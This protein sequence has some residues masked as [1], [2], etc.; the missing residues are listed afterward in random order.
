[1]LDGKPL[2][3]PMNPPPALPV[4]P[5]APADPPDRLLAAIL[6]VLTLAVVALGGWLR[7]SDLPSTQIF[8][9]DEGFYLLEARR[10]ESQVEAVRRIVAKARE[11]KLRG[12]FRLTPA[13][14]QELETLA[15]RGLGQVGGR[16]G[17]DVYLAIARAWL[18]EHDWVGAVVG[19][20]FGTATL[21]LVALWGWWLWGAAA[22]LFAAALLAVSAMHLNYSRSTLSET[23]LAFFVALTLFIYS[24]SFDS[25]RPR[26]WAALAGVAF[27]AAFVTNLRAQPIAYAIVLCELVLR[28]RQA[29][30]S[31]VAFG[32]GAAVPLVL[33]ELFF[34]GLFLASGVS[35]AILTRQT[36]AMDIVWLALRLQ[37]GVMSPG[38]AGWSTYPTY[39]AG[40]ETPTFALVGLAGA[41]IAA[42]A[43]IRTRVPRE[44]PLL[45]SLVLMGLYWQFAVGLK[46]ARYLSTALPLVAVLGAV[47][48][49]HL[50]AWIAPATG[51]AGRRG[52]VI[53]SLTALVIGTSLPV[54]LARLPAGPS[55]R[56]V[57]DFLVAKGATK[58][59]ATQPNIFRVWFEDE[60]VAQVDSLE[61]IR[62]AHA[63]GYR[64]YVSCGQ[65]YLNTSRAAMI[66]AEREL[67]KTPPLATFPHP[68]GGSNHIW[69]ENV[70]P[71]PPA[72][73]VEDMARI[74]VWDLDAVF[75][76]R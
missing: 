16:F 20:L 57:K 4:G 75:A 6:A 43:W 52:L 74:R 53:A 73:L 22:G 9:C 61:D 70:T 58:F 5:S 65:K 30:V 7:F 67:A 38:L 10:I 56:E 35:G 36:F 54:A 26:L 28:P 11:E 41:A 48:L 76:K 62:R 68:R 8:R 60:Q 17:H 31:L 27:G 34:Y 2:T 44:T 39:V 3:D 29:F 37:G 55:Y 69:F 51:A 45:V 71:V 50:T 14:R 32:I 46:S 40:M 47:A 42:G 49:V 15:S 19:A 72:E 18:G 13:E 21:V 25:S 64:Y 24:K 66:E 23:D 12:L 1:M 59:A 63:A 33:A